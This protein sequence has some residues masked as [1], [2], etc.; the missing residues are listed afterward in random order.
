[1]Y[2]YIV[3]CPY[4]VDFNI[5]KL[6]CTQEPYGRLSTYLT[7]CPPKPQYKIQYYGL[8]EINTSTMKGLLY[9][10]KVLHDKFMN[11]RM[12]SSEWFQFQEQYI[13][14]ISNY[15][16]NCKFVK[17]KIVFDQLVKPS[18][19]ILETNKYHK[20]TEKFIVEQKERNE[21]LDD[22]QKPVVQKLTEFI[23]SNKEAGQLIAPCG[24]GKTN[25][26]CKAINDL[27]RIVICVPSLRIQEQWGNCLN[28]KCT[29]L[30]GEYT[31]IDTELLQ[32]DEYCIIVTYASCKKLI[33]K[34]TDTVQLIIFDEAHHMTGLVSNNK[35]AG[36]GITRVLL[37]SLVEK[38]VKRLFLT[39]TPKDVEVD[40]ENM[41]V[42]SMND[43]TIFGKIIVEL[44]LRDLINKGVL[45]DYVVWALTSQGSGLHG[46]LEQVL[47]AWET[48]EINHLIIFV[49]DLDD[50]EEVKKYLKQKV[51]CPVLSVDK[52]QDTKYVIEE[53]NNERAILIDCKRL[54]EGV[55]IPIADSVAVLY[56]KFSTVDIVQMVLR[57]GRWYEF[58]SIFHILLPHATDEDMSGIQNILISLAQFDEALRGE[59]LLTLKTDKNG[60]GTISQS[61][62][63]EHSIERV[64]YDLISSLDVEKMKTC[65]QNIRTT[66]TTK[67]TKRESY[68]VVR[69]CNKQLNIKTK[70][71]YLQSEFIHPKYI[72]DPKIYF[73][74]NWTCWYDF[75]GVDISLFP[76]TKHDFI[77]VCKQ[78]QIKTWEEYKEKKDISLPEN[79]SEIYEDFTNWNK[80]FGIHEELIIW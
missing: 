29:Y 44:K 40:D 42:L 43:E 59:V 78:K 25:M 4:Y 70:N 68:E 6:G 72:K 66:L 64:Q 5:Y 57:A 76:K 32:S 20:N 74:E 9:Y 71:Q 65:F 62:Y 30:G 51:S 26:T 56:P 52:P 35:D 73:R 22:I 61:N 54:G 21:I 15:L 16:D 55:D 2:L 47:T 19:S 45:P 24:S 63:G 53:F 8:W 18:K 17:N 28:K 39:F 41:T 49:E 50:K 38:H 10:E 48:K 36:E 27:K 79:P 14:Q 23:N 11:Y 3:S 34:L 60:E 69:Y 31:D 67:K 77:K 13:E 1:M 33:D 46:K 12:G 37:N 58:K 80:E 75:L 7:G